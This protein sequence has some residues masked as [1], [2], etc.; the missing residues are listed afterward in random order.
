[1]ATNP[2]PMR[3]TIA[4]DI[5]YQRV[6]KQTRRGPGIALA[7]SEHKTSDGKYTD[8]GFQ[9]ALAKIERELIDAGKPL[10]DPGQ[11][12][13]IATERRDKAAGREQL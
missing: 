3:Q 7:P 5:R 8:A 9:A 10:N 13:L 6:Q 4:N 12:D 2:E 11:R 1:M